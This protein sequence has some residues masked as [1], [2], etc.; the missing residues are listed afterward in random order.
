MPT[1]V[2]TSSGTWVCPAG[3][4]SV[5]LIGIGKGGSG[6]TNGGYGGGGGGGGAWGS[7]SGYSVTPGNSYTVS[8]STDASFVGVG[9]LYVVGGNSASG[10]TAGTGGNASGVVAT[11]KH[12]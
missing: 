2:F 9:V 4:T 7:V 10:G 11:V 6:A 1:D 12:S 5:D 8:V 3:V